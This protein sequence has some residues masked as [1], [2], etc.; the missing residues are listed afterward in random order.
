MTTAEMIEITTS[1]IADIAVKMSRWGRLLWNFLTFSLADDRIAP[2]R[3][4]SVVMETGGVSVVYRSRFLS[5]M[6]I[7]GTRHYPFEEGKYPTPGNLASV[8]ALATGDLKAAGA[9]VTLVIP[10]AWA[11]LKTA[12]FPL[13]V[14]KNLSNVISY[15]LD[16]LTPL[17]SESALYD[18]LILGEDENRIRVM[19]AAMKTETLQ[20]YVEALGEKGIAVSRVELAIPD[21]L[22]RDPGGMES[23]DTGGM[24]LLDRGVHKTEKTPVAL[25]LVLL[26]VLIA[27]GLFWLVSPLQIE[28]KRVEAIDRAISVRRDEVKK[29]E[30]LKKDLE[31]V[32][33]ERAAI[34][35]FRAFRL[36]MLDLLMELTRILPDKAWLSR[37][38]CTETT[39]EIDGYAAS[40]TDILP[41]LE[42][43]RYFKKVEFASPTIRDAR[44]NADHFIIKMEIEGLPEGKA[45]NEKK[46]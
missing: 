22:G 36:P 27:S 13:G 31:K 7:R 15:E 16:R 39:V 10:E 25:T 9:Q 30:A 44:L 12:E 11:I 42:T 35:D 2:R 34:N 14:K 41:K 23:I 43:S 32:G 33:K 40:A 18:F 24:N 6:K 46:Q 5:R 28:E 26:T 8:V 1:F 3:C 29:I 4:L 19:I 38:R 37:V 17:S 21:D 20:P 45:N